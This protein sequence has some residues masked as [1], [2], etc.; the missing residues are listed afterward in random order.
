MVNGRSCR[1]FFKLYFLW[2][3]HLCW[4]HIYMI[5]GRII[6]LTEAEPLSMMR[7]RWLTKFFVIGDVIA[8][9]VQAMGE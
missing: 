8:F 2:L 7:K 3:R 6:L 9:L 5:L 1:S 4:L